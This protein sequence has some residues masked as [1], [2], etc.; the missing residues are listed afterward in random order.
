MTSQPTNHKKAPFFTNPLLITLLLILLHITVTDDALNELLRGFSQDGWVA[1]NNPTNT[2]ASL[3]DTPMTRKSRPES[4]LFLPPFP[5]TKTNIDSEISFPH[6]PPLTTNTNNK[7]NKNVTT[8]IQN[9]NVHQILGHGS[10]L[11]RPLSARPS[12]LIPIPCTLFPTLQHTSTNASNQLRLL[13]MT[14]ND[15][16]LGSDDEGGGGEMNTKQQKQGG[17]GGGGGGGRR[18]RRNANYYS[19]CH[20]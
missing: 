16:L 10:S 1:I 12:M 19:Y 7:N 17:G 8:T 15:V 20:R 3:V 5:S 11:D 6:K 13:N 18:R 9:T 2:T 14:P 4:S